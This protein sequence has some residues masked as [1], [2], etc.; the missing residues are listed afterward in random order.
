MMTASTPE[1]E[2]IREITN[3]LKQAG[4][5]KEEIPSWVIAYEKKVQDEQGFLEWLQFIYLPNK[6]QRN[7]TGNHSSQQLIA[8][9]A[10]VFLGQDLAKGKLLRLLVE[11]DSLL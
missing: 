7:T 6:L 2:K 8:P 9:Q 11:L 5:W 3:E 4:L 1:T 10:R